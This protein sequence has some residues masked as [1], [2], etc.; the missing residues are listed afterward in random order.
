MAA[1]PNWTPAE[2]L[3][4]APPGSQ[5]VAVRR[6]RR[7]GPS[8]LG[9]GEDALPCPP[10]RRQRG[11][12]GQGGGRRAARA[13]R[14]ARTARSTAPTPTG[15]SAT[16]TSTFPRLPTR[17]GA[18]RRSSPARPASRPTRRSASR[19][20][21]VVHLAWADTTPGYSVIYH[22]V[23]DGDGWTYAPVPNGKGSRPSLA[24]SAARSRG[25]DLRRLAGPAGELAHW[26]VRSAGGGEARAASGRCRSWSRTRRDVHSLLPRIAASA[27]DLCHMVWQEE[28]DGLVCHPP[29]R[30]VAER[31]GG[32]V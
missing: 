17:S 32:A 27:P 21:G 3:S 12:A 15:S 9:A 4:F 28:R 8:G 29:L 11:R 13:G 6:R 20:D 5:Q 2:T 16:A 30:P 24:T 25:A 31:L 22:A 14:C 19:P 7:R 26:G 1:D 10:G 23:R 18:S